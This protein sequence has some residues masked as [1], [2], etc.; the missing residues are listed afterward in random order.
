[1][2][3]KILIGSIIAITI[4][5]GVSFTS[6][7][8]YRSVASD[9]KVSPLFNIRSSR[10]IGIENKNLNCKYASKGITLVFPKRDDTV[11]MIQKVVDS[12]REMDDKTF[13]RFVISLINN[14]RRD[15]R[16]ND[17]QPDEIRETF[18]ILRNSDKLI[19]IFDADIT[20]GQRIEGFLGWILKLLLL[21]FILIAYI[22][23]LILNGY[24]NCSK[25]TCKIPCTVIN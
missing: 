15:K 12:I 23:L 19:P 2:N 10:A 20:F 25:I 13:E 14:A 17:I 5:I 8:G 21:P 3:K 18:N 16:F 24:Q 7:V 11:V 1:M 6:V 4:L 9:V 22:I